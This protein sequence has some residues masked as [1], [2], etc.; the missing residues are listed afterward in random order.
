LAIT[1]E[2]PTK[3][4]VAQSVPGDAGALRLADQRAV[5]IQARHH[6]TTSES[7]VKDQA[8][9]SIEQNFTRSFAGDCHFA[10]PPRLF[11]II[12]KAGVGCETGAVLLQ[13]WF[14]SDIASSNTETEP[15]AAASTAKCQ[16]G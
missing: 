5:E 1:R 3:M 10:A 12:S 7:N 4:R 13:G 11:G 8:A 14:A 16:P 15:T 9:G 6:S 2:K